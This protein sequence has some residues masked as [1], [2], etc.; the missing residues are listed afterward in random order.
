[1][2]DKPARK[3]NEEE[4]EFWFDFSSAYAYFGSL[5]LRSAA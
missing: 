2:K 5:E 1:M 4:I 3:S